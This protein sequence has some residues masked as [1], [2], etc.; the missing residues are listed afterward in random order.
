MADTDTDAEKK[1][2][3]VA[4]MINLRR[5]N[6]NF[7]NI[8]VLKTQNPTFSL[9]NIHSYSLTFFLNLDIALDTWHETINSSNGTRNVG[10]PTEYDS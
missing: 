9:K 8:S 5:L 10:P 3:K 1:E 6:N 4:G 2:Y 7:A